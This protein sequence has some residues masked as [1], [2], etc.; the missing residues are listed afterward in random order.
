MDKTK[1]DRIIYLEE[2]ISQL[3]DSIEI[4]NKSLRAVDE[5][6]TETARQLIEAKEEIL[7]LHEF[8]I[9]FRKISSWIYRRM[10]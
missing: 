7:I 4:L 5:R 9:M 8:R 2:H 6:Q 3:E 1:E 10:I